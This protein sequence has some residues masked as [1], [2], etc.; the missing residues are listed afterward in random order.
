MASNSAMEISDGDRPTPSSVGSCLQ[1]HPP[2]HQE[3]HDFLS[4]LLLATDG[5]G[6][7]PGDGPVDGE[8]AGVCPGAWPVDP[9][10]GSLD[11]M[12]PDVDPPDALPTSCHGQDGGRSAVPDGEG[13]HLS[14][15]SP[16]GPDGT[17]RRQRLQSRRLRRKWAK[18]NA[19]TADSFL[20]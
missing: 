7:S 4:T 15:H 13:P 10:E 5:E 11:A 1:T 2:T 3:A 19:A 14:G 9:A 12:I 16:G 18:R 8:G 20:R 17:S 6:V